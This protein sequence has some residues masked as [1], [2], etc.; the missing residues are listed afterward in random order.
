MALLPC[1]RVCALSVTSQ[2]ILPLL[3]QSSCQKKYDDASGS[4]PLLQTNCRIAPDTEESRWVV[5]NY[6]WGTSVVVLDSGKPYC[7]K[8]FAQSTSDMCAGINNGPGGHCFGCVPNDDWLVQTSFGR[9]TVQYCDAQI[10]YQCPEITSTTNSP[11]TTT[12]TPGL[13]F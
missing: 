13:F 8:N 2:S 7:T 11:V 12:T 3:R 10:L 9:Y 1:A 5:A 6:N 4:L